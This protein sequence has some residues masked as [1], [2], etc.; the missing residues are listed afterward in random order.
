MTER[1]W[2]MDDSGS[3]VPSPT[4]GQHVFVNLHFLRSALRRRWRVWAAAGC[5]GVLLALGYVVLVPPRTVGT[6][7][8]ILAHPPG[9]SPEAEISTDVSLVQTRT[10]AERVV[11]ELDLEMTPEGFLQTVIVEPVS[12]RVLI[13]DVM[14]PD[15]AA[16]VARAGA[17]SRAFLDFRGEQIAAASEGLIDGH[18]ERVAALETRQRDLTRQYELLR[19]TSGEEASSRATDAL[20]ERSRVASEITTLQQQMQESLLVTESITAASRVLDPATAVLPSAK[21]RLTLSLASGLVG[22]TA[23]GVGF[24]LFAAMT[25][26]RLRRRDEV[27]LALGAPVRVSVKG[28]GRPARGLRKSYPTGTDD[29]QVLARA[30]TDVG[31][32]A[33]SWGPQGLHTGLVPQPQGHQTRQVRLVLGT[34]ESVE[35]GRIVVAGLAAELAKRQQSLFIVDLT[36]AGGL[37]PTVARALAEDDRHGSSGAP[38]VF[39]PKVFPAVARG[40]LGV[41]AG[42]PS[43]LPPHDPHRRAWDSADVALTLAEVDPAVGVDHLRSWGEEVVLLVTAGRSSTER[44]RSTGE[45]VRSAGLELRFAMLVGGDPRDESLG[46]PDTAGSERVGDRGSAW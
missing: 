7:T 32:P 28:L 5:A 35:A 22:G 34:I 40:P 25:S 2:H 30:L 20:A 23:I 21:R 13:L 12:T 26:D 39:R 18:K 36:R 44:L 10:V 29:L 41:P 31:S 33:K 37:E 16:A 15:R 17:L 43:D 27:A 38:V 4:T 46:L 1:S 24:V 8:L 3:D 11:D 9:S 6:V 45:L 42:S 19:G 14:A